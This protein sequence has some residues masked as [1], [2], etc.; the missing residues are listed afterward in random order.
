MSEQSQTQTTNT[1]A[2]GNNE[3]LEAKKAAAEAKRMEAEAKATEVNAE[4][5]RA[6][7]EAY[8][9]AMQ[10]S[11]TFMSPSIWTQIRSMAKV[12][13]ES[14]ALPSTI[15]NEAKLVM[16]LQA[17]FEMGMTPVESL[18][19]L[20]IVN[21]TINVYGKALTRRLR[22]HGWRVTYKDES[23]TSC[24]AR[25]VRGREAYEETYSY[26]MAEKS[27]YTKARSGEFKVGWLPG[28]NRKLK[29]RYGA[30]SI[31]IK[32]YIPDVLGSA[33]D[34]KEMAED[35]TEPEKQ[36]KKEP[37]MKNGKGE[38]IDNGTLAD[39]LAAAKAKKEAQKEEQPAEEPKKEEKAT[40]KAPGEDKK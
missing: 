18:H 5:K 33:N 40:D 36:E 19:S 7:V 14:R 2:G 25:V 26:E 13:H 21:G 23:D 22:E 3:A 27:G 24:T 30:L 10:V 28:M 15:D 34:I 9:R 29:L 6:S 20:Y 31:I 16:V 38:V 8:E 4:A 39:R 1:G 12:F 37:E 32:S 11:T 17:G 35:Y